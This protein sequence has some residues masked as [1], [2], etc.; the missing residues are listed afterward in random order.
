M[1]E[2]AELYTRSRFST[3]SRA[4]LRGA[5][6]H[7]IAIGIP[8]AVVL[9]IAYT[10]AFL[11]DEPL[12]RYTEAK[13]NHALKGYT[14]RIGKLDFHPLG[15][16]LDLYDV[17]ITQ[18][19]YPDPPVLRIASLSASVHWP[20]LLDG[21]LVGDVELEKP[22]VYLNLP[23]ARKEIADPTPVKERGWQDALEAVYPLKINHFEIRDGDI[24]YV[25]EGPFK[26]LRIRNLELV[27]T[28]IRNRP[29]ERPYPSDVRFS[30]LVFESGRLSADGQAD[31][32][33]EPNPA[34]RGDV[35]LADIELDYFKPITNRY[36]LW[37]DKGVLS[38]TGHAEY[39]QETKTV[40]LS[41]AAID[42]IHVDYV[43][44]APTAGAE[45][46]TRA[47]AAT[48]AKQASNAPDLVVRI[49]ELRLTKSTVG[50][51]NKATTPSYRVFLADTDGTLTNLS[52]QQI[53]G[54]AVA[55][56]KG[57]FMGTGTA[58]ADATFRAD[59]AGPSF[60]IGVRIEEVD[61]TKLNDIFR[62]YGRFDT[63]AGHFHLYSELDAKDGVVTGYIKPLFNDLKIYDKRQDKSKPLVRKMYE[64]VV[65]GVAKVL[66]NRPRE[67]VA[68][69]AQVL[70]RID[71]PK[72]GTVAAVVRLLQNALINAI[73]PG[74][75]LEVSRA[76]REESRAEK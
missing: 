33:A 26:P 51:V 12:R 8:I 53:E 23:Q 10:I 28:N 16:A 75:D 44:T 58:T 47:Q 14:A 63:S 21:R 43:H 73:L 57:A 32:L 59:K 2:E 22:E 56:L 41:R 66:K 17:V 6:R 7:W 49:S 11:I 38:A 52:N 39:A 67:E 64:R 18:D 36:N 46:E 70:G 48:A 60:D 25:D 68:T 19:A 54:S 3:I 45:R 71:N 5:R 61:V 69:K 20:A 37:V 72:V 42:G 62:A 15:Y 9:V 35:E 30:A 1:L 27:A 29:A 13:M 34:F 50:F 4:V 76:G 55:K 24:T 74:F 65:S 40:A 31:F